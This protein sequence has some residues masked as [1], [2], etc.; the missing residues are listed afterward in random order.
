MVIGRLGQAAGACAPAVPAQRMDAAA[1]ATA[2][3]MKLWLTMRSSWKI[4]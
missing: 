1:T 4:D 2:A 3:V